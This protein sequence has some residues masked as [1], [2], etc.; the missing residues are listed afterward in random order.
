LLTDWKMMNRSDSL[1]STMGMVERLLPY[2]AKM[3]SIRYT[4]DWLP[5]SYSQEFYKLLDGFGD[6]ESEEKMRELMQTCYTNI[7]EQI[8]VSS[9]SL[10]LI[11]HPLGIH[12]LRRRLC[13]HGCN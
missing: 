1:A 6:F 9:Q 7:D 3:L 2:I 10:R 5:R 13:C 11:A 12:S 4:I 8:K